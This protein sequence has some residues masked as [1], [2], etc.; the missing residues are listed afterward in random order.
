MSQTHDSD[1]LQP[2]L[3]HADA[4]LLVF[5]KPAGLLSVPGIGPDKQIGRA[6]V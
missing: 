4:Q 5:A 3:L 1:P 2:V 6:H